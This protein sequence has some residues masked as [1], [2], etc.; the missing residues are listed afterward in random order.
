[1]A[2]TTPRSG[3]ISP[4]GSRRTSD[5]QDQSYSACGQRQSLPSIHES[6]GPTKPAAYAPSPVTPVHPTHSYSQAPPPQQP[7]LPRSHPAESAP[8]YPP[9]NRPNAIPRSPPQPIHPLQTSF[10]GNEKPPAPSFHDRQ[11]AMPTI[12]TGQAPNRSGH[13]SYHPH[14]PS[15]Y[16]HD[17][18]PPSSS[19]A[20]N[21]YA[22]PPERI[23]QYSYPPNHNGMPPPGHS[24]PSQYP[25]PRQY[26]G[27]Y[28]VEHA[29]EHTKYGE[30]ASM[31]KTYA[32]VLKR[33]LETFHLELS[34]GEVSKLISTQLLHATNTP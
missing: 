4:P 20:P 23:T 10:P 7:P 13:S 15:R 18:R 28:G 30:P 2:A 27:R 21:G 8:S 17:S 32:P 6:L 33:H 1:M 5:D 14:E 19:S 16:E 12:Q 29:E 9:M 11:S 3:L 26:Q 24:G 31:R 25:P 34:L 22:H